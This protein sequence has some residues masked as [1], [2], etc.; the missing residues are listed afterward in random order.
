MKNIR[1]VW[2]N[3]TSSEEEQSRN[4]AAAKSLHSEMFKSMGSLGSMLTLTTRA[5]SK[6]E[7]VWSKYFTFTAESRAECIS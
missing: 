6:E 1:K 7:E 2:S 3:L 5:S 4:R